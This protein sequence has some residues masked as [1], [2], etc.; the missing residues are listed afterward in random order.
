MARI[1]SRSAPRWMKRRRCAGEVR[2][3]K[4]AGAVYPRAAQQLVTLTPRVLTAEFPTSIKVRT[5]A[6]WRGADCA[7]WNFR[8]IAFRRR[9]KNLGGVARARSAPTWQPRDKGILNFSFLFLTLMRA[10]GPGRARPAAG[11]RARPWL[12]RR[13]PGRADREGRH[14]FPNLECGGVD[15]GGRRRD[16]W[17]GGAVPGVGAHLAGTSVADG[18]EIILTNCRS[19]ACDQ[20]A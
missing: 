6:A 3:L 19:F 4:A 9:A 12:H 13:L 2:A 1:S 14:A 18:V 15:G 5:A 7:R 16:A 20:S 11:A 10:A 17:A 8:F